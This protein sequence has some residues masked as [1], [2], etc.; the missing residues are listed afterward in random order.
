M[1][2]TGAATDANYES[3]G[4]VYVRLGSPPE[5]ELRAQAVGLLKNDAN[6]RAAPW[7]FVDLLNRAGITD[8]TTSNLAPGSTVLRAGNRLIDGDQTYLEVDARTWPPRARR[9]S[10]SRP[11]STRIVMCMHTVTVQPGSG[12]WIRARLRHPAHRAIP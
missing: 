11:A 1:F 12:R 3:T 2:A 9:R 4:P 10:G 7:T 8:V 6:S 5:F